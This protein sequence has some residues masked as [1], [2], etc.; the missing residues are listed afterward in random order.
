MIFVCATIGPPQQ[1]IL[2]SSKH[3]TI[4][5]LCDLEALVSRLFCLRKCDDARKRKRKTVSREAVV[6]TQTRRNVFF[7]VFLL[8]LLCHRFPSSDEIFL[9]E[10]KNVAFW[11]I[12]LLR[13]QT[14]PVC[15]RR[16]RESDVDKPRDNKL[17]IYLPPQSRLA[18]SVKTLVTD[19]PT[20]NLLIGANNSRGMPSREK[21]FLSHR[22]RAPVRWVV[23]NFC[24]PGEKTFHSRLVGQMNCWIITRHA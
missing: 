23:R 13:Q 8:L 17:A 12:R 2:I 11:Y 15:S 22:K 3:T 19:F 24:L 9:W 4:N 1:R 10:R 18:L 5:C 21:L 20:E 6:S 7:F 16:C 14:P